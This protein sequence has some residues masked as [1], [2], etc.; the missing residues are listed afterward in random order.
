MRGVERLGVMLA[1][2]GVAFAL[3]AQ[4]ADPPRAPRILDAE[5]P[6]A[7]APA[8]AVEPAELPV[9]LPSIG[10]A[11]RPPNAARLAPLPEERTDEPEEIVVIGQGWRLPDLGSAWRARQKEAEKGRRFTATAL[12][13]YDPSE[14]PLRT[15]FFTSGEQR[16]HGHIEL[17][18]L[19][20]GRRSSD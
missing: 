9:T 8:A 5:A 18:R 15:D 16:R 7:P 2:L 17:F 12:P 6:R 1:G 20:F 4:L 10:G 3:S 19:R 13:L 11:R 14:P